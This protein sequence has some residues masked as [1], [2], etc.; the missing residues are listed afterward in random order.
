MIAAALYFLALLGGVFEDLLMNEGLV[1]VDAEING[2]F[3]PY[4]TT[5]S[6]AIFIWVTALGAGPAITAVAVTASGFLWCARRQQFVIPLWFVLLGAEATS[7]AG[8]Y[9]VGRTRPEFLAVASAFSPSFPSGHA[10]AS[11]A[12][13]GFLAYAIARDLSRARERF[14]V[15]F[16]TAV[17]ILL[18]GFSRMF[19][20]LHYLSDVVSGFLVGGFWLLV[21]F[22]IVERRLD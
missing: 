20:S 6:L 22:A 5:T 21:G 9:L 11:M 14:E 1:A 17:L 16:W 8:K 15:V 19:L 13:Y 12:V 7:F 4:R 3:G 2:F 10:T 18:I